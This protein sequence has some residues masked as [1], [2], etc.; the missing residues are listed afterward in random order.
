MSSASVLKVT[1]TSGV[2]ESARLLLWD[3][4]F[5][6]RGRGLS[7]TVHFP[8]L[9]NSGD[10]FCVSM[11]SSEGSGASKTIAALVIKKVTMSD[12]IIGLVGLVC[13]A[14]EWR[15]KGLS[16][17]LMSEAT[18]LARMI[19]IDALVLWTQKPDVYTGQNFVVD[20]QEF[21]CQVA[22]KNITQLV[23]NFASEVWPDLFAVE[24][25]QGL[26]SFAK[27]GKRVS[28]KDASLVV[29]NSQND[30][31][32]LVYWAGKIKDVVDLIE[33]SLPSR[34]GVNIAEGHELIAE[35]RKR[36]FEVDIKPAAVR[37]VKKL[38]QTT[39]PELNLIE[40]ID[41]V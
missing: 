39:M 9:D 27:S 23:V 11:S 34:W 25:Q 10:V 31:V 36:D 21:F 5:C 33:S 13:V 3:V 7:L 26:P 32:T 17:R 6:S 2:P 14:E 41:R 12:R 37:M 16:S 30:N 18:E 28:T 40:F 19:E 22:N 4:F 24:H 1:V 29:V 35:L 20:S 38:K 8:W 15:G